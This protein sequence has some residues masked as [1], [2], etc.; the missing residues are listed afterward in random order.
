MAHPETE[1]G[2]AFESDMDSAA[3]AIG[4]LFA[5]DE[6]QDEESTPE[7]EDE[8][9]DGEPEIDDEEQDDEGDE[10][11]EPAIE[12]P[13]SLNAEEKAKFAQLPKEAQRL[14]AEVENRRNGQ[15]QQATTKA[16]EAQRAAEQRAALADAQAKAVYAQQLQAFAQQLAPQMPDPRLAQQDP[17]AYIAL[18]AQYDADIAQYNSFV[19]QVQSISTEAETQMTQAEIAERDAALM[20]IPEVQNPETRENFFKRA[21][22]TGKS[23]GLDVSQINRATASELKALRDIS[24]WKEK[25][26]KYDAATARQMQRVREGKKVQAAKPNAASRGDGR[27]LRDAK[28]R[29]RKSGDLR[30]AAAAI[31]RL[32]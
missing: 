12:A 31:A 30:D 10:P 14:I 2:D 17:A 27:S 32:G 19:Q 13:T 22:E 18:K 7:I 3:A 20:A 1:A 21:I 6:P 24:D 4:N 8:A 11:D 25:A 28:E 26:E 29:L 16:A 23:L 15:V 5:D 9:D